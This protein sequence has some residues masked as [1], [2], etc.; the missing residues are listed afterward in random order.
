MSHITED[1]PKIYQVNKQNNTRYT[2]L[3]WP[4]ILLE[5]TQHNGLRYYTKINVNERYMKG[6]NKR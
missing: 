4:V 6:Y 3:P 5:N 1:M 2:P